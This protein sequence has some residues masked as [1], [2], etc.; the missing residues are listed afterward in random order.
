MGA[1]TIY[2]L[3]ELGLASDMDVVVNG[4]FDGLGHM[5]TLAKALKDEEV[6]TFVEVIDSARVSDIFNKQTTTNNKQNTALFNHKSLLDY[7]L[8]VRL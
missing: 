6:A 3:C 8:I 5:K 7:R 4:N 2:V 1:L